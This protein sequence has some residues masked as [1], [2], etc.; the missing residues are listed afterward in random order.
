MIYH[1]YDEISY[2]KFRRGLYVREYV[3]GK[4]DVN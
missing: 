1:L 2:K 4:K 3:K